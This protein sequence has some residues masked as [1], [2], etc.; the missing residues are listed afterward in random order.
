MDI[1]TSSNPSNTDGKITPLPTAADID[2]VFSSTTTNLASTSLNATVLACSDEFFAAASNLLTPTPPI[3]RPG[4]FVHTGAWYDGWETRRHNQQEYDW[5]VIKLGVGSGIV[6]GVEIDTTYF[7]G[8]YGE[9][10][11]VEG[12]F[13]DQENALASDVV[14]PAFNGWTTILPR[15]P[16]GPS[17]RQGWLLP[18]P[19]DPI[20]HVRLRMYP[21]GGFSRLRLYGHAVPPPPPLAPKT[22]VTAGEAAAAATEVEE[23]SSALMGGL[24]VSASNQHFTP[25]SN[26]LLPGRGQHMGDGWETARSR[27][28]GHVD[29]AVVRLGLAGSVEKVVVDTKDF[30]GNFPRAVRVSGFLKKDVKDGRDPKADDEGWVEVVRGDQPCKADL[31][32]VFEGEL[33][34]NEVGGKVFS[35]VMLTMVPDGGVKRFRVFGRRAT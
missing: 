27:T 1:P 32:H 16:C 29:R 13:V 11:V 31:E 3:H 20:T 26:I 25:A 2:A 28:P 4:V 22:G 15:Q 12:A 30:R 8:N 24:V 9:G 7:V 34:G 23:L 18:R 33:L 5:V 10:V 35:H 6:V 17:R 14:K 21:D 19:S